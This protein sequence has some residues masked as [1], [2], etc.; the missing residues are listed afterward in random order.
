M[1]RVLLTSIGSK[2]PMLKAFREAAHKT[3]GYLIGIDSDIYAPGR[4]DC[5]FFIKSPRTTDPDWQRF[6]L[7]LIKKEKI[8]I[9]FPT[10]DRDLYPLHKLQ[11][12]IHGYCPRFVVTTQEHSLENIHDKFKFFTWCKKSG[13]QVAPFFALDSPHKNITYPALIRRRDTFV[14]EQDTI[15]RNFAMLKS[16]LD[17]LASRNIASEYFL[18]SKI[19]APEFSIDTLLSLKGKPVQAVVRR[20]ITVRGGEAMTSI[21]ESKPELEQLALDL[22]VKLDLV[23]HNV[24]QVF[25]SPKLGPLLIEVNHRF[26]GASSLSVAAGLDSPLRLIRMATGDED[27]ILNR[28][29]QH[30]LM[31]NRVAQD[32]YFKS[33]D[34]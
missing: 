32:R 16:S 6:M 2:V 18:Q 9:I 30:G 26:G 25:L 1:N 33:S 29:I 10:S 24:V 7:D 3:G 15:V 4:S 13:Y 19:E 11:K 22:C 31:L 8:S 27:A 28:P 5:D 17:W 23:G 12:T 21:V 14:K 20:R 34:D